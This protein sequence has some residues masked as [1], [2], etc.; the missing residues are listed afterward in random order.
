LRNAYRKLAKKFHPDVN[1]GNPSADEAFKTVSHAYWILSDPKRRNEYIRTSPFLDPE[2]PHRETSFRDTFQ[3]AKAAAATKHKPKEGKNIVLRLFLTLN[4]IAVGA[5]KKV[6]IMRW[7]ACHSCDATGIA[8]GAKA[9]VC[10]TC[11]G[12][13]QVPD[14]AG[15]GR[16]QKQSTIACR[17]CAG[18]G[19]QPMTACPECDGKGRFSKEVPLTVGIPPGTPDGETIIVRAQGHEGA[20]GGDG[21]DLQ[22]IVKQKQHAYLERKESDLLYHCSITLTQWIQGCELNIPGL[23]GPLSLTLK[24]GSNPEGALKIRGRGIPKPNG[25]RGDLI[26]KYSLCV[27]EKLTVKQKL[28]L[29]ALDSTK[30]FAPLSD[31]SGW[32][33]RDLSS[34]EE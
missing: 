2:P 34:D 13:G 28:L 17:K 27:P 23:K 18:S 14:F 26:V 10:P 25:Q 20:F 22:V 19:L 32:C 4:E 6:K 16:Q 9:G 8:G 1:P 31:D 7:L 33:P 15:V 3:K 24:P 12:T 5:T 21:G 30:G 29:K 11:K